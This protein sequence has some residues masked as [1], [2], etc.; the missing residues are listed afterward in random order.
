M[1]RLA[2]LLGYLAQSPDDP[3][4]IYA[5]AHEH[6]QHNDDAAAKPYFE[7]L[8]AEHPDYLPV[9]YHY[10]KWHERQG[11]LT[12]AARLYRAGIEKSGDDKHARAELTAALLEI[13]DDA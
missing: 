5:V 2:T 8:L 3:F 4:L 13:D 9:Y 12:T 6:V 1:S 11:D 7:R 10:G